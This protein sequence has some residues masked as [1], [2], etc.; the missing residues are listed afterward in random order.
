MPRNNIMTGIV[1]IIIT[2]YIRKA[3]ER[4]AI[5]SNVGNVKRHG[6]TDL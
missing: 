2:R 1:I 6:G 4:Q 3:I 5:V